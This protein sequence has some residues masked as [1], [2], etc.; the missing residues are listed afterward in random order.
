M[1]KFDQNSLE[2]FNPK[3]NHQIFYAFF[4]I[5]GKLGGFAKSSSAKSLYQ[6]YLFRE[7]VVVRNIT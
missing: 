6:S 5:N 7:L 1:T 3:L 2:L 4:T